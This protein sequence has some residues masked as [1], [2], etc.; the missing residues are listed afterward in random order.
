M[1]QDVVSSDA[2]STRGRRRTWLYAPLAAATDLLFPPRCTCCGVEC[3]PASGGPLF[4]PVCDAHLAISTG[5]TCPRCALACSEADLPLANC[6]NCRGRRLRF[7]AARTTGPYQALL[8]QAVLRA[9]HA[10]HE[11]LAFALG[12]RLAEALVANPLPEPL[13]LVVPVPMHWLKRLWRGTNPAE[14]AARAVA[15]ELNLPLAAGALVCRRLLRRQATLSPPQRKA[16][17]RG[18]FRVSRL[19]RVAGRRILL[20]DDVMT[21]GATAREAARMLGEAGAAAVFVATVARSS[22]QF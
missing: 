7:V 8:R 12:R 17:V 3:E 6:G 5:P 20:V 21:T 14:T 15:R 10:G 9:K 18:A 16:N 13:D 11:P 4:C 19:H 22:P 1:S 2:V